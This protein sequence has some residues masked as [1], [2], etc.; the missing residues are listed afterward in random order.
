V[1]VDLFF[2]IRSALGELHCPAARPREDRVSP[3]PERDKSGS[4]RQNCVRARNANSSGKSRI[5]RMLVKSQNSLASI[6]NLL[7][8]PTELR[9]RALAVGFASLPIANRRKVPPII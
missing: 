4:K 7:V 9:G 2:L 3:T 5:S 1:I 8:Y 6:R